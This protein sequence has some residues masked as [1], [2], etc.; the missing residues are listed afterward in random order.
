MLN[1]TCPAGNEW[2]ADGDGMLVIRASRA[3]FRVLDQN[4]RRYI[5][6]YATLPHA[7]EA[8]ESHMRAADPAMYAYLIGA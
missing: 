4:A 5:G 1:W 3:G 7:I 8:A 6:C 2:C